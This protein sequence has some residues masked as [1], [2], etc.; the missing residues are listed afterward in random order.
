M[1]KTVV[2]PC[3]HEVDFMCE[4]DWVIQ[5][6]VFAL[7]LLLG[8]S[9]KM[10]QMR[11]TF[12]LVDWVR[13]IALSSLGGHRPICRG[14]EQKKVDKDKRVCSVNWTD[15]YALI[16]CP[17]TGTSNHQFPQFSGLGLPLLIPGLWAQLR[18]FLGL[19]L[20]EGWSFLAICLYNCVS[21]FIIIH[22][23]VYVNIF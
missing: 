19:Y 7:T 16:F 2:K 8:V 5:V 10:F 14:S 1:I 17:Q 23:F 11:L 22:L 9:V 13:Q 3:S 6:W 12:E 20:A 21:Q 15:W 18:T 4:I